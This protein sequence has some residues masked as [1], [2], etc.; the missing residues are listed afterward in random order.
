MFP[1]TTD[2]PS[3]TKFTNSQS[4]EGF[5]PLDWSIL[6]WLTSPTSPFQPGFAPVTPGLCLGFEV[7]LLIQSQH[8][9]SNILSATLCPQAASSSYLMLTLLLC[10]LRPWMANMDG[11][12]LNSDLPVIS[13]RTLIVFIMKICPAQSNGSRVG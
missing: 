10:A 2:S 11:C 7:S 12:L 4:P 13:N 1:P 5:F 3:L 9:I 8:F 6:P